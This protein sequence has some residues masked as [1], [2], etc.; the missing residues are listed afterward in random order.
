VNWFHCRIAE[1]WK[2]GPI[3]GRSKP[4][5]QHQLRGYFDIGRMNRTG[6]IGQRMT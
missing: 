6:I 4:Q 2:W 5:G 1:H 3:D